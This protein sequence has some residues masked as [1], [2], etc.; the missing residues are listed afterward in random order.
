MKLKTIHIRHMCCQRCVE[1]VEQTLKSL[2]LS[3]KDV[4]LGIATFTEKRKVT[5]EH[6]ADALQ[7]RGFEVIVSEDERLT[8]A[9]KIAVI[10]AIHHSQV[11]EKEITAIPGLLENITLKSFKVLNKIFLKQT[12][13]TIQKYIT[14][15]RIE[16]VKEFI[17]EGNLN[18]SQ[19]AD[20]TGYKTPQH[21][22]SQFKKVIGVT[23]LEYKQ[24]TPA[25][26]KPIDQI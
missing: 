8:E 23:M 20:I 12:G 4:Q 19:I 18:F 7:K 21:L 3:V 9:V 16:R 2:G 14:L 5:M 26:R 17:Q 24:K 6:I 13:L 11:D 15:Q 22:S 1:A 10:E 25:N